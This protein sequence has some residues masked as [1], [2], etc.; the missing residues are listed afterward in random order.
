MTADHPRAID[1]YIDYF[2]N[3]AGARSG[4]LDTRRRSVHEPSGVERSDFVA[5]D[6]RP[7]P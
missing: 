5:R 4:A 1:E 7:R 2:G 6:D 3:G